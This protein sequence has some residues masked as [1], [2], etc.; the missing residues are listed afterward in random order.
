MRARRDVRCPECGYQDED[1]V[2]DNRCMPPCPECGTTLVT[3]WH[4]GVAPGIETVMVFQPLTVGGVTFESKQ[5]RDE[6]LQ[7]AEKRL[8]RQG[9]QG[10]HLE[11]VTEKQRQ[12][13]LDDLR[14]L[15]HK[16][17][18][19]NADLHEAAAE[20]EKLNPKKK[21]PKKNPKKSK[22]LARARRMGLAPSQVTS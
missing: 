19:A 6:Y 10:L 14:H 8:A 1:V 22:A 2:A 4:T 3:S 5:A 20:R 7:R 12:A 21:N 15:Q 16:E 9:V 13:E 18:K 17:R 11:T